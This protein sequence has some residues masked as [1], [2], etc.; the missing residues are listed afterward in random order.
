MNQTILLGVGAVVLVL[1]VVSV[2]FI[3]NSS[4]GGTTTTTTTAI[5]GSSTPVKTDPGFGRITSV[6][7]NPGSNGYCSNDWQCRDG[8]K[9]VNGTCTIH[10]CNKCVPYGTTELGNPDCLDYW[11]EV[12]NEKRMLDKMGDRFAAPISSHR[13]ENFHPHF[14]LETPAGSCSVTFSNRCQQTS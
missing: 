14:E 4:S 7:V 3:M 13:C 11:D 12:P 2:Y 9:C 10:E 6:S 1:V 8:S 5:P